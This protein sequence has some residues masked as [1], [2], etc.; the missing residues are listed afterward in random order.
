MKQDT[1]N[2][3]GWSLFA[4]GCIP[5]VIEGVRAGD[6]LTLVGSVLFLVGVLIVIVP[7]YFKRDIRHEDMSQD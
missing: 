7:F 3:T 1:C 2:K 6:M 4:I 5:F